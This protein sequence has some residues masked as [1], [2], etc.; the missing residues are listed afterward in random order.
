MLQTKEGEK[1]RSEDYRRGE[2]GFFLGQGVSTNSPALVDSKVRL[3]DE[4]MK[5]FLDYFSA[6]KYKMNK[7]YSME[8]VAKKI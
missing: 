6:R 3:P 5:N 7:G 4:I 1:R 2:G 8:Q